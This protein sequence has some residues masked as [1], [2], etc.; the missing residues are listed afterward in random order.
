MPPASGQSPTSRGGDR[1]KVVIEIPLRDL[2]PV[3]L[4]VVIVPAVFA[5]PDDP[6]D[7][8]NTPAEPN[9]PTDIP[10][11]GSPNVSSTKTYELDP[12]D[13]NGIVEPGDRLIYTITLTNSGNMD[14]V[15]V[16]VTDTPGTN[17]V[18]ERNYSS[19]MPE[20][21][22]PF[23]TGEPAKWISKPRCSSPF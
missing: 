17:T 5:V 19:I 22:S 4:K 20:T 3:L 11:V 13:L 14:A 21:R 7:D 6:S 12:N 9:D 18:L 1:F 10:V 2:F 15:G 16:R 23:M 8:P